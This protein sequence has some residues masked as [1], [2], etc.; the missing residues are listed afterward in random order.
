M[1]R[2]SS[3]WTFFY[4][5]VFPI[6]WCGIL[7]LV[8]AVPVFKAGQSGNYPP[9]VPFLIAPIIMLFVGLSFMKKFVFDFVDEVWDD[10][11]TLLVRNRGQ[12]ERIKLAD[13]KNV[14]SSQLSSPPRITLSLRRPSLFGDQVT[15]CGPMRLLP[16]TSNPAIDDLIDRI[17]RA[18]E[19]SRRR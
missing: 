19:S 13:I 2:I 16:F 17:D 9:L 6:F 1:R 11:D 12:E 14:S 5:R 8:V 4:K 7:I 10:G 15:F 3:R 18:R